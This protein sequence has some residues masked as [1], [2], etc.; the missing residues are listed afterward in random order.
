[1]T[2]LLKSKPSPNRHQLSDKANTG[3]VLSGFKSHSLRHFVFFQPG[4]GPSQ[5]GDVNSA[6][7]G[8]KQ[9]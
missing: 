1:M 5:R 7:S 6:R 4:S 3:V 9:R 8:R 2:R